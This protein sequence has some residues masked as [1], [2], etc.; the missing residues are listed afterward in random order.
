MLRTPPKTRITKIEEELLHG[1]PRQGKS[2]VAGTAMSASEHNALAGLQPLSAGWYHLTLSDYNAL[3]DAHAQLGN[4]QTDKSPTFSGVTLGTLAGMLKATAGVVSAATGDTDYQV[5][6]TFPQSVARTVNA[7]ALSGDS[8]APG[9]SKLYGTDGAGAKG[10]YDLAAAVA[11]ALLS[12]THTDTLAAAVARGSLVV[13]N[14]T[15]AWAALAHPGEA[16]RVLQ[17]SAQ[18]TAW[19]EFPLAIEAASAIDQDLRTYAGGPKFGSLQ[20]SR[21]NLPTGTNPTLTIITANNADDAILNLWLAGKTVWEFRGYRA[22]GE[23]R[24]SQ[25]NTVRM[26]LSP[27]WAGPAVRFGD[28]GANAPAISFIAETTLGLRR[29][30]AGLAEWV[31]GNMRLPSNKKLLLGSASEQSIYYDSANSSGWWV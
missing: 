1:R 24:I 15:P 8:A 13:G 23:L 14:V 19:S 9:N 16:N 4:L 27:G 22:T 7:I 3:T 21:Y 2:I 30:S 6:L 26:C 17:S 18:D 25:G 12:A 5:A 29:V 20:L 31:G 10:W 11:H 28:G